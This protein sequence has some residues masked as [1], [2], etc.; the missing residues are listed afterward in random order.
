MSPL[1]AIIASERRLDLADEDLRDVY[2]SLLSAH[3]EAEQVGHNQVEASL[4]VAL[5]NVR[6]ELRRRE[7]R[8]APLP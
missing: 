6:R 2:D 3:R 4:E 8:G 5:L 1:G 7:G